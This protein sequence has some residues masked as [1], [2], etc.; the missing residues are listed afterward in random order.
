MAVKKKRTPPKCPVS[1]KTR[2]R[3]RIAAAM[4]RINTEH[5]AS[6][7]PEEKL[8]VRT[9]WCKHCKGYHISTKRNGKK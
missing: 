4:G 6:K 2:F 1:G 9:Y 7:G 8:I 5:V 3:D